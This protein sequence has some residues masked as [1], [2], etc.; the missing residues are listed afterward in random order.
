MNVRLVIDTNVVV[1][2]QLNPNGNEAV[3]LA[4]AL[5]PIGPFDWY[6]SHAI[7]AEYRRVL[8]YNKFPI[9][10]ANVERLLTL[11]RY[12]VTVVKPSVP[13]SESNHDPDN[14]FLECAEASKADYLVTGNTKHFPQQWKST[15][16]VKARDLLQTV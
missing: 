7:L 6:V 8:H 5:R 14:R 13:V 3:V 16:I 11:I 2:G 15:K 10:K 4:L 12:R 9:S 1:S